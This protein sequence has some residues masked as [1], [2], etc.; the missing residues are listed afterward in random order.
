MVVVAGGVA[1]GE[2]GTDGGVSVSG[3]SHLEESYSISYLYAC[4]HVHRIMV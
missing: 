1:L 2:G 3:N 4:I